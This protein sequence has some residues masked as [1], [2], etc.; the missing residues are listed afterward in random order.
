MWW[1]SK[2]HGVLSRASLHFPNFLETSNLI[3]PSRIIAE[4]T[5]TYIGLYT[6]NGE[7][8]SLSMR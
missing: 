5:E 1:I 8:G 2:S 4:T 3:N 7:L 6:V